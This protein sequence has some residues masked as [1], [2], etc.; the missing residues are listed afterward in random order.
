MRPAHCGI[1]PEGWPCIALTGFSAL[2]FALL[3]WWLPA[4]LLLA[5]FWFSLHFFRDPERVTPRGEGLAVSPADGRIIRIEDRADPF[6]GET[7]CCVSIFMNILSV[8]VNRAPV[9]C[10]VEDI[11]YWPGKFVNA[12][13][14]K[15]STDNERC[16][17]RLRGVDGRAWSMVQ[18]AGL[19]A[20]RIVC[21]AEPGD[22]LARG[23]RKR[24]IRLGSRVVR[25][26]P[27]GYVAAVRIGEQ[28]FAGQS[29]IARTY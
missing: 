9:D 22:A 27:P 21:R 8:H 19:V 5:L 20:R 28:V 25:Y 18:I 10:V 1:T 12:A 26:M 14:D 7:C 13:F 3:D 15:A 23:H 2:V 24:N 6:S 16:A 29:V 11:R 4:L 17:Y